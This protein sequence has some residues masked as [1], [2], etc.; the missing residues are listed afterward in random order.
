M[1]PLDSGCAGAVAEM[2]CDHPELFKGRVEYVR[3]L[4]R[5]ETVR[6]AVKAVAPDTLLV[7]Q[8]FGQ[9]VTPG[10]FRQGVGKG[11]VEDGHLRDIRQSPPG[12][13]NA[14]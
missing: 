5:H 6:D 3:C 1:S 9:G 8:V 13:V 2:Q 12:D 7:G 11:S 4:D 14:Q 10:I